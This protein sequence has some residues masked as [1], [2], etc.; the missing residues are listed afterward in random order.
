[1]ASLFI[2]Y[3]RSDRAAA[4]RIRA[5]LEQDGFSAVFIDLDIN[6]GIPAGRSWERELYSQLYRTDA[7]VFLASAASVASKW[8]FTEVSLARSLGRPVFPARLTNGVELA[9]LAD[10]QWVDLYDGEQAYV[11]LR[12]GLHRAGLDPSRSHGWDP[13]RSPYPGLRSF[14]P[15][16]A[17]VFFGRDREIKRL[18]DLLQPTLERGRGRFVAIIGPSGS[19]K[20]SLMRA[21]LLPRLM[22]QRSRWIVLPT[23]LPGR[24]PMEKLARSVTDALEERGRPVEPDPDDDVEDLSIEEVLAWDDDEEVDD[25]GRAGCDCPDIVI[26]SRLLTSYAFARS[27]VR[28]RSVVESC[29]G[30]NTKHYYYG[31]EYVRM[32]VTKGRCKL[33]GVTGKDPIK[34]APDRT[35]WRDAGGS[36]HVDGKWKDNCYRLSRSG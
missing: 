8:C 15:E 28:L 23:I 10:V 7:V 33:G 27:S 18:V 3:S 20:S 1:M 6:D 34:T 4:E 11:H 35:G 24:R 30:K 16:D 22:M 29:L 14:D 25:E 13:T 31:D 9:L 26:E 2:S 21:G 12:N 5:R 17:A 32:K 36:C 19:G